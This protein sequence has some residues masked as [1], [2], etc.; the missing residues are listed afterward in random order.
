MNFFS[1]YL[2]LIPFVKVT[3][4]DNRLSFVDMDI[5]LAFNPV[6]FFPIGSDHFHWV[7][8]KQFQRRFTIF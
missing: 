5:A 7:P 6:D 4:S 1:W 2:F 8:L 3:Q